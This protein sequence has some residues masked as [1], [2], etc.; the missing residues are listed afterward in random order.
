MFLFGMKIMSEALQR[1]SGDK[2]RNVMRTMTGNRIAGVGTGF[3]VTCLVQSSS[4]TTVMIVSFVNAGLLTLIEATGMI[5]GANIGTTTTF[6]LVSFFGF[7]FSISSIALPIMGL[8]LPLLFVRKAKLRNLGEFFMGFGLLFIGLMFLKDSVPDIRSN[9]EVLEFIKDFTGFGLGSVLIFFVF[10]TILTIVVQSSSVAGAI[11][12]TM[13]FK[14]W[15]DYPSA[16]AIILGENVGTTITAN[17]AALGGNVEAKRAARV[18]LV[19]NL[20]GVVW[21]IAFFGPFTRLVDS[22]VP[23]DSLHASNIPLHMAGFHSLFNITNTA[24]LVG[25]VPH[26]ARLATRLVKAAPTSAARSHEHVS[27]ESPLVPHTGELNLAEAERDV[28]R[29]AEVTRELVVGFADMFAKA[30]D[31]LEGTVRRM[32]E[33]EQQSD[34]Q[35]VQ[36]T[37][38]LLRCTAGGISD[39]AMA[40]VTVMIR[41]VAEFEDMCDRGYRLVMLAER[42]H[43]KKRTLPPEVFQQIRDFSQV[44]LQ[45]MDFAA[46]R[47]TRGVVA[48]DMET[49]YQLENSIDSFRQR[50]RKESVRRMQG[51]GEIIKSE[52]LYIDILNNMEVI[53]DHSLNVLQALR[54]SD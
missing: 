21:C 52:M 26:L 11:T 37:Q 41:V 22:L 16:C 6:W 8:A 9:P 33:L 30:P 40:R 31:D 12:L 48:A 19:F 4:A 35:A 5:M 2:L 3:F 45:F 27:Y 42:K 39:Q 10:G 32:K 43:R 1:L 15:I 18:H 25:F 54:H 34:R 51:N 53:G 7:K 17:L 24:L 50:L 20:I 13:A 46:S 36:T 14:G 49:A 38:Y 28:T 29:M 23:G 44:L 47:L